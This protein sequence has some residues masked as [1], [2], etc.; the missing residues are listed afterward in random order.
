MQ[1]AVAITGRNISNGNDTGPEDCDDM[2]GKCSR[3]GGGCT[4]FDT[5]NAIPTGGCTNDCEAARCIVTAIYAGVNGGTIC[6]PLCSTTF[7]GEANEQTTGAN[8]RPTVDTFGGN[9]RNA[10]GGTVLRGT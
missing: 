1:F 5:G 6:R 2:L 8:D 10:G 7:D 3:S 4:T 9:M